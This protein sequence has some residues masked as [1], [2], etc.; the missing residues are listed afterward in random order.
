MSTLLCVH[1]T[2]SVI[3]CV[4]LILKIVKISLP[5]VNINVIRTWCPAWF[6]IYKIVC[7]AIDVITS[8]WN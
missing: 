2:S 6:R 7:L 3:T 5:I 1:V 8:Q 4:I